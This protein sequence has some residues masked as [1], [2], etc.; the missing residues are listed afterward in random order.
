MGRQHLIDSNVVIDYLGS[1]L[2]DTG[3][4]FMNKVVNAIPRTSIITKIEVLGFN[5]S[6]EANQLLINFFNDADV[7]NITEAIETKTI[8][9]RKNHQVKLPDAIIA[10][11][12]V[13]HNF[14]LV[15]RNLSDFRNIDGLELVNPHEI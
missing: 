11:T 3:M 10:A 5:T 14:S 9:L 7:L 13:V 4:T 15:T 6:P 2:P 12:A 8:E 1:R